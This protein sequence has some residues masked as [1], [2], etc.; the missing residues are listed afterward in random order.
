MPDLMPEGRNGNRSL[1]QSEPFALMLY[2][3]FLD[4]VTVRQMATGLSIPEE[5]IGQ[6]I[7]AAALFHERQKTCL[8]Q[9]R[10]DR[11]V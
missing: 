6:R 1:V 9:A 2:R 8:D 3:C 4:G 11:P 10:G 5:R 7:R